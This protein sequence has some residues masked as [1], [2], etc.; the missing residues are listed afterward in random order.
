[1]WDIR[2]KD[3][4]K[5]IK[6]PMI[7]A[8]SSA[9]L[10]AACQPQPFDPNNPNQQAKQGAVTGGL[11][12]LLAG[13]ASGDN[14]KERRNRALGGAIIGAG[15]GAAVGADLDR[16]AAELQGSFANGEINVINTGNEL[17]VR[18]PEAILFAFDSDAV[19]AVLRSDLQ[20]LA[21]S[22]NK[23]QN[24]TVQVVGHTDNVGTAAYNQD[25]SERR[26]ANVGAILVSS[27][28]SRARVVTIGQGE[29][30]PI[31]SNLND[32]GRAQNRRVDIII[33]PNG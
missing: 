7:L 23:Y 27:G 33:T 25:L 29:S 32:A 14:S 16:Q 20:V 19:R 4:M 17:I 11:L 21:T 6:T 22:L 26:A 2:D 12:G 8:V 1:M 15:I 3:P 28:V 30:Q 9:F 10:L 31:A 5:Y 18:M 13:A 24:T